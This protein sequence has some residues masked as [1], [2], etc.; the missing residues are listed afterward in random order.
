MYNTQCIII[1]PTGSP[2]LIYHT[3]ALANTII[4]PVYFHGIDSPGFSV[5]FLARNCHWKKIIIYYLS[6][7]NPCPCGLGWLPATF[8]LSKMCQCCVL[9]LFC[10]V[11]WIL[12][13]FVSI[14]SAYYFFYHTYLM[15]FSLLQHPLCFMSV[16]LIIYKITP[17]INKNNQK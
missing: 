8:V 2:F 9:F 1:N 5:D 11:W 13:S 14:Q 3:R 6:Y 16:L 17:T 15:R 4:F 10:N 7:F 12:I